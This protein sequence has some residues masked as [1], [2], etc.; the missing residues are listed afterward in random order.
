MRPVSSRGGFSYIAITIAM[1]LGPIFTVHAFPNESFGTGCA[2]CHGNPTLVA[3]P[4]TG[5]ILSIG[6]SGFTLVG[7]SSVADFT[8][9]NNRAAGTSI[10]GTKGG[11]F[12]GTFPA[13][14]AGDGFSTTSPLVIV[15]NNILGNLRYLTPQLSQSVSYVY[16]PSVRGPNSQTLSFTPTLGFLANTFPT[17][18]FSLQGQ[19]VAPLLDLAGS[20]TNAGNVRLGASGTAATVAVTNVGDGN[21]SGLGV[22]SNLQG[23]VT[24]ASGAFSGGSVAFNLADAASQQVGFTFTPTSRGLASAA[25]SVEAGNG[26]SDGSN[27]AQTVLMQLD[28]TGVGPQYGASVVP[29]GTISFGDVVTQGIQMLS[30]TNT[31]TDAELGSL[32]GLTLLSFQLSGPDAGLFSLTGFTAGTVLGKGETLDL[33]VVFNAG[34]MLGAHAATLSLLTDEAAELGQTGNGFSYTLSAATIAAAPVPEPEM[35]VLLLAGLG[36]IGMRMRARRRHSGA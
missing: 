14:V 2:G 32:T 26:H 7:Q 31:T 30:I 3:T 15:G 6:N 29:D 27:Q 13:P 21:L 19:G 16:T 1:S 18:S 8:L 33:G 9:K 36:V 23:N 22:V 12:S 5:G 34:A 20:Q 25:I 17:V 28:G 35:A 10:G 4:S 11:G 24:A